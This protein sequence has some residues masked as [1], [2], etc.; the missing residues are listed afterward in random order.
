M[1]EMMGQ[2]TED[3]LAEQK[4]RSEYKIKADVD[5]FDEVMFLMEQMDDVTMDFFPT[6][7]EFR[8]MEQNP[9]KYL[10]FVM[11]LASLNRCTS[12]DALGKEE[13]NARKESEKMM[14]EFIQRHIELV[15]PGQ[16]N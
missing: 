7:E 12:E 9:K 14:E 10:P 6:K 8:R 5:K 1:E 16:E 3:N 15:Y 2:L 11:Y 13:A 4:R